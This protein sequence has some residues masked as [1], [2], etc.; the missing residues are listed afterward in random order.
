MAQPHFAQRV[1]VLVERGAV[2]AD[3]DAAAAPVGAIPERKCRFELGLVAMIAPDLAM[4][5]SS[6]ERACTQ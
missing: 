3:R 1:V 5:P 2:D 4:R 6:P